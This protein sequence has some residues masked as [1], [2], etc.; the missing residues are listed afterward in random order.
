MKE[1]LKDFYYRYY[2]L[3]KYS[4]L[5]DRFKGFTMMSRWNYAKNLFLVDRFRN[6]PGVVVECGVWRGGM[7]AGM[8]AV[9]G[10]GREYYLFDSF[11]GLPAAKEIDGK[12]M[13]KWQAAK[14]APGY[15][16]NCSAE[17]C[18]AREAMKLAGA[19]D[20]HIV[21]GW[22]KDTLPQFPKDREIAVLRL[23]GDLFESTMECLENLYPRV[24][25]GGLIII[26]DYCIWD[27][28]AK[29]VHRFLAQRDLALKIRLYDNEV[30]FIVND[31]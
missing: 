13:L 4:L 3:R 19:P 27:G 18:F 16:N 29:A 2:K 15:F 14:D 21:K 28:C 10:P 22:F 12:E 24:A 6:V 1:I 17:E 5:Y 20:A 9:L 8:A 31:I 26:D 7:S 23:D 30:S 25:K 11:Q